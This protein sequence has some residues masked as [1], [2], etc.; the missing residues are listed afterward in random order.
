MNSNQLSVV[1][2]GASGAV[3]THVAQTLQNNKDIKRLT[4][5]GRTAISSLTASSV[6]QYKVDIFDV[7]SYEE[8]IPEHTVAICTLGVGEPSKMSKEEFIK[9]DKIAVRDFAVACKTVGVSHFEL[10]ASV[11][12]NS[13]SSSFYLKTKG[14]LVEELK[15]LN[16]ERLSIFQPSMILTPSNRYGISQ[17]IILK[18]W[19]LLKP[20]LLG[21][22]KKYRGIPVEVLGRSM[23]L[24]IFESKSGHEILQWDD[25]YAIGKDKTKV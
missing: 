13:K 8:Y 15:A 10:L 17:A 12:I 6:R 24:N 11:G 19:P 9:I 16:F 18:I 21:S 2:L 5:L 1:M 23:A 4:L 20:L 14:E 22:L 25:F 3:G 7:S